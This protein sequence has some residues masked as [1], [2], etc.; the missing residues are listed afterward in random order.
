M[1]F[2]REQGQGP[3]LVVM[4]GLFGSSDNW[5]SLTKHFSDRYRVISVDMRN[6]GQSFH[7]NEMSYVTMAND[8]QQLIASLGLE[9]PVILGHSMGGKVAMQLSL[10]QPEAY[11]GVIIADIAPR[12]YT[13]HHTDIFKGLRSIPLSDLK[14]RKEADLILSDFVNDVT[15]RQ[16]LLKSLYLNADKQ[17]QWRFNLNVLFQDYDKLLQIPPATGAYLSNTLF[18]KGARSNYILPEDKDAIEQRFPDTTLKIIADAGHWLHAEKPR[19]F[20]KHVSDYLQS[21]IKN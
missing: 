19:L 5:N 16:F 2:Y 11:S 15:T 10:S 21:I 3:A 18:L 4:H 8:I 1:L 7:S 14:N 9:R 20:I 12:H 6:H 17:F 13:A